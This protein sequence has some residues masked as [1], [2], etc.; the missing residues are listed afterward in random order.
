ML[1]WA[2]KSLGLCLVTQSHS[3][4]PGRRG[5]W[6]SSIKGS[7]DFV[8]L[9]TSAQNSLFAKLAHFG[10]AYLIPFKTNIKLFST[11]LWL[12]DACLPFLELVPGG[13]AS[14]TLAP[15]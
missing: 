2:E 15:F 5:E 12:P 11:S 4:L 9:C 7:S 14:P 6:A 10:V 3:A 8:S 1:T 13:Q